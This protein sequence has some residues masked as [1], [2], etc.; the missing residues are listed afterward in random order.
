MNRNE[1][2]S[3]VAEKTGLTKKQAQEA[4]SAI[5]DTISEALVA[6]DTVQL[7]GFGTFATTAR[8]AREGK[9]PR[10]GEVLKIQAS[11][12]AKFRVGAAL[13]DALNA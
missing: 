11:R 7:L 12:V 5:T 6:G 10:T 2:V 9:N 13:K 3:Q 8:A 4:L 1:L